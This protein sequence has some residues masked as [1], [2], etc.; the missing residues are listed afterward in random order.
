MNSSYKLL[1]NSRLSMAEKFLEQFEG[2]ENSISPN[3]LYN[4]SWG[5][6]FLR[7]ANFSKNAILD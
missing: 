7:R 5:H 2:G 1:E 4:P 3:Y 6:H